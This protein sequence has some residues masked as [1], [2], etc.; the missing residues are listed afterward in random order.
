MLKEITDKL[1][2]LDAEGRVNKEKARKY[3]E[4]CAMLEKVKIGVERALP[5][6]SMD[7][8]KYEV[9]IVYSV[10]IE[11][12]EIE[13]GEAALNEIVRA[14]NMLGLVAIEDMNKIINAVE[15]AV[16]LNND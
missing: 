2:R 12:I 7:T 10:P 8:N 14:L 6:L 9:Q 1:N 3:E 16:R 15:I 4:V 11:T 5:V 13:N